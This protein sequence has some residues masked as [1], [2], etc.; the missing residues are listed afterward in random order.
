MLQKSK[1]IVLHTIKYKDNSLI[2]YCYSEEFGRISFIVNNASGKGKTPG[3]AVYFQPFSIVDIVF[4]K[5][6][7][8]D[9]C[10]LK[11]ISISITL[12]TI[13][14]DPVKR[15]IALFLCE[16]V[17]RT[18]KE[19]E[20]NPSFYNF[21]E[22]AIHLLDIMQTGVAN[23]HLIFL[24]QHS[25]HL[26]FYPSNL[27]SESTKYFDYKNG[28]FVNQPPQHNFYLDPEPSELISSTIKTPFYMAENLTLSH[29]QRLQIINGILRYY[30]FHL[31][32][33]LEFNSLAVLT[34]LFE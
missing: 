22:N 34:Q 19:E 24:L 26:G 31:G 29:N 18:V 25:R 33:S 3:N 23:F 11:E 7:G 16:V 13:P 4:Y 17:Y 28:S 9:L 10:R 1:A 30:R 32:S 5:K 21:L 20:P 14:F 6:E 15:S 8:T 2:A 12:N 27:W